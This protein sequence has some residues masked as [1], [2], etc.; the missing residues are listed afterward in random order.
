LE[1]VRGVA[2]EAS[3]GPHV[4]WDRRIAAVT[5]VEPEWPNCA[6]ALEWAAPESRAALRLVTGLGDFWAIR[7]RAN[8]S[9]R[10]GMP[11]L[12]AGDRTLPEWTD[13][14]VRLQAVRTN[15]LDADYV[16]M[17]D[18]AVRLAQSS[19]DRGTCISLEVGP[20]ITAVVIE[21]PLDEHLA[22]LT[23]LRD[24]ARS[25]ADW[26]TVWNTTQSPALIL[27]AAGRVRDVDDLVGDYVSSRFLLI[28]S[29]AALL[30][31]EVA[32][33]SALATEARRLV[34]ARYGST[35]DRMLISFRAAG[36]ALMS[37]DVRSLDELRAG[38]VSSD[39][40]PRSLFSIHAMASG[41]RQIVS[42][43]LVA[44][45]EV[46]ASAPPD[47]FAS[48]R[49]VGVLAQVELA[50]GDRDAARVSAE[51]LRAIADHV[52]A[53]LY[54]TMADLVLAECDRSDD[55]LGAL[56]LAHRA[57]A[58]ARDNEL[59]PW[60]VDA[61]ETVGSML[62][63][64][65]RTRDAARLLRAADEARIAMPYPFRFAHR[66]ADIDRVHE[67]TADDAGWTAG[68]Q[69]GAELSLV[70]A[71]ELAQRMRGE[72]MRAHAGWE[73]ITPTEAQV[74]EQVVAGLT[75]PQ[76]AERL[77]M[78]RATVKTHLV[79]VYAKLGISNRAELAA[80][81]TRRAVR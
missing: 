53:P 8:D 67:A 44:A 51:Q 72:R 33:S 6:S 32:A 78:S 52:D 70:D 24:E 45:R 1:R 64:V 20:L 27:A 73:S 81:A 15:A 55:V 39:H 28:R 54:S 22:G 41:V 11:P 48:W 42:G 50:L 59:W 63:D 31:G 75:N 14:V 62:I 12:L 80:T 56:T 34:D 58:T 7:Q 46:L 77:I 25:L 66:A 3:E 68:W 18:A 29:A 71:I 76:I 49:N 10:F 40:L 13:A 21:G 69:E 38:D 37:G 74:I 65:G 30:R 57:L 60:A 17:R 79:H 43:D 2:D 26:S 23:A 36:A 47:L 16:E 5:V 35:L 4:W 19:G 61:L 9:A